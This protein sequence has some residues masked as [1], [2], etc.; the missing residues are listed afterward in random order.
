MSEFKNYRKSAI[1]PMRPYV[2]GEILGP[3][4]SIS[5]AD[6]ALGCPKFGDMIAVNPET[7]TD[8]WLIEASFFAKSYV[9]A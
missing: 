5:P 3:D 7:G 2:P 6:K 1:Q 8:K 4:V 9:P